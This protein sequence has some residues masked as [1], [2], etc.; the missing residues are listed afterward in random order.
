M[1]RISL[2]RRPSTIYFLAATLLASM[3]CEQAEPRRHVMNITQSRPIDQKLFEAIRKNDP[4]EVKRLLDKGANP[5]ATEANDWPA[6]VEAAGQSLEVVKLLVAKGAKIDARQSDQGWTALTR[7]ITDHRSDVMLYLLAR[8]ADPTIAMNDGATPLH[9]AVRFGDL[10]A[11]EALLKRNVNVDAR[12]KEEPRTVHSS[13]NDEQIANFFEPGYRQSGRTPLF[14]LNP[15]R[16][17]IAKLLLDAGG[18][19]KATDDNGWT[20]LHE[21]AKYGSVPSVEKLLKL[22]LDPNA[23]SLQDFTPLHLAVRSGYGFPMPK[24]IKTLLA[25]GADPVARN[26]Q[27][28]TPEDLLRAD[29]ARFLGSTNLSK[30]ATEGSASMRQMMRAFNEGLQTLHPGAEP[31]SFP[32]APVVDGWTV[33]P[34]LK[35]GGF[36]D[37]PV[38]SIERKLK[39]ESD[40]TQLSLTYRPGKEDPPSIRLDDLELNTY[41][42]LGT[43]PVVL[44]ANKEHLIAFPADAGPLGGS[45]WLKYSFLGGKW[46]G[47][48]EGGGLG[49]QSPI[50]AQQV[51]PKGLAI[52]I[53][54]DEIN[55]PLEFRIDKLSSGGKELP[56]Y[57]GKVLLIQP[58]S[59][60]QDS[61]MVLPK[62]STPLITLK[63]GP[64]GFPKM[65]IRYSYR[66]RGNKKWRSS[67][68][69]L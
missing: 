40:R 16:Q 9:M 21:A 4:K 31:I 2:L 35:L 49:I 22:G 26:K 68:M 61:R 66:L 33:Y 59:R 23:R 25:A 37:E 13:E 3:G 43:L 36:G 29:A 19:P 30:S 46:S 48:G 34:P 42:P 32:A 14:E 8:G 6:I 54:C 1:A 47:G 7:S 27:G 62:N 28:Q 17:D 53:Y 18:D 24:L 10:K 55:R 15:W 67:Q 65:V 60:D 41:E 39:P 12:T 52:A 64:K 57:R 5:N 63:N 58:S 44:P 20:L 69:D 51:T 50:F 38:A 11:V 56:E 45:V